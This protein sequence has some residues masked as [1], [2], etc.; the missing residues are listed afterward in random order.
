LDRQ[1]F[2]EEGKEPRFQR[3]KV[4]VEDEGQVEAQ[5]H[6]LFERGCTAGLA[7]ETHAC[8]AIVQICCYYAL[9]KLICT[10]PTRRKL[11]CARPE[12][13]QESVVNGKTTIV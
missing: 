11:G 13:V 2:K 5:F 9:C 8:L 1:R 6:T 3:E 10:M 12:R 4:V 7:G